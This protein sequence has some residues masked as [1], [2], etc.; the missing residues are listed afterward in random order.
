MFIIKSCIFVPGDQRNVDVIYVSLISYLTFQSLNIGEPIFA[1]W[2]N[3]ERP[4]RRKSVKEIVFYIDLESDVSSL[5]TWVNVEKKYVAYLHFMP[6][7]LNFGVFVVF[8][9]II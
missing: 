5:H 6:I 8:S 1:I 9:L 3:D 7:H 2:I 4:K